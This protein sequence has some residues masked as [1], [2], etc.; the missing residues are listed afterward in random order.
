MSEW[1][2]GIIGGSGLY[3]LD[4]LEDAQWIAVDTPWGA[5]VRRIADRPDRRR[6]VRVP[7]A[8]RPRPPPTARRGQLSRQCRRAE[9][10]RLHRSASRSR[11]SARCARNWRPGAS[12]SS[13]S[14]STGPMAARRA[15][16]APASSPMSR[17]PIRSARACRRS[18]RTRASAAGAR[19]DARRLL[20]RDRRPAILDPRGERR[21]SRVGRRRDRHDRHARGQARPRGGAA[22]RLGLHGHR[23]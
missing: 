13:T 2:I 9:A 6:E 16:S 1:T 15:S 20:C 8:P 19:V 17:W 3:E 12:S 5:A 21:L 7:A 14:I 11:R 4:E 22:L 23:L 18:P 10:R